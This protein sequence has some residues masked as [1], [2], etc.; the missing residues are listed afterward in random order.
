VFE[1]FAKEG[2]QANS[3]NMR[4]FIIILLMAATSFS[5]FGAGHKGAKAKATP[6][7]NHETVIS[8]VTPTEITVTEDKTAKTYVLTQ[9]TEITLN[10]NRATAADLKPGMK[11]SVTIGTDATHLSRVAATAKK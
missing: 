1:S 2:C 5:A 9:F 6:A 11:V 4:T 7:V 10:G 8:T 3:K